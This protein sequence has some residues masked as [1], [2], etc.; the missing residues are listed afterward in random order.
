MFWFWFGIVVFAIGLI[1]RYIF[2]YRYYRDYKA[3]GHTPLKKQELKAHYRPLIFIGLGIEVLG[4][5]IT[6]IAAF[7]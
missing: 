1:V 6:V 5:L 3:N 2:K 7:A 4:C